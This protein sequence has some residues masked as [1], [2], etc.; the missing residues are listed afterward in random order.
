HPAVSLKPST[1]PC[2][3]PNCPP[4]HPMKGIMVT[5]TLQGIV[6]DEPFHWRGDREDLAAFAPAFTGLQGADDEPTTPQMQDFTKFVATIRFPPNPNRNLDGTLPTAFPSSLGGTGNAV[7]GVN[8]YNTLPT[9]GNA[10]CA[11]CHGPANGTGTNRTI[12]APPN[13]PLAPQELKIAQLRNMHEKT[14][15]NRAS[16]QSTR[17]F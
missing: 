9:V 14:G 15:F 17:G 13:L 3:Q 8:I 2:R 4:W 6:G 7:N 5:Q 16:Q 12:D 1:E 10:P 11:A